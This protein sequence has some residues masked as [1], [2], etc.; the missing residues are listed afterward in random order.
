ME[1]LTEEK[2]DDANK[3]LE[4]INRGNRSRHVGSTNMNNESSRSHAVFT[5]VIEG[6]V[7]ALFRN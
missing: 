6:K 1:G 7:I 2:C 3:T 5:L 4:V